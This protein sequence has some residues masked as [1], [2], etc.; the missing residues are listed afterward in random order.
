MPTIN[1]RPAASIAI[2]AALASLLCFSI[3][4]GGGDEP[5]DNEQNTEATIEAVVSE[6]SATRDAGNVPSAATAVP[7]G[8]PLQTPTAIVA[9]TPTQTAA[10]II[11][12]PTAARP[13]EDT[14]TPLPVSDTESFLENVSET[15][16]NCV[17]EAVPPDRLTTLLQT[18][19]AASADERVA[20]VGCLEHDTA[21][22]LFL[23][24]ILSAT[25]ALSPDSTECLR[26]GF[27][28]TDLASLMLAAAGTPG[29]NTD[30]EAAMTLA[31]V[32]S[33][34][35]LSCLNEGE[36]RTAGPAMGVSAEEYGNFRCVVDQVGGPERMAA[37]MHTGTGFPAPLFEAAF[38]CE[39]QISGGGG[40]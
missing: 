33:M 3:A 22:R 9:P 12:A 19:E 23:T 35:S 8:K 24:P 5:A 15:E 20:L 30:P 38:A 13:T 37:L 26:S 21:L 29:P 36:F 27:A 4:C 14:L 28:D 32:S 10:A 11:I 2:L 40:G 7:T 6:L 34:V 25:G 39:V 17:S 1:I 31:M 16:R 18:P